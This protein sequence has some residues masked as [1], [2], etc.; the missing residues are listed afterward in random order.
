MIHF[1]CTKQVL[2]GLNYFG[3]IV[4]AFEVLS[5]VD[6][7]HASL[8]SRRFLL[9]VSLGKEISELMSLMN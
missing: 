2:Q 6:V 7:A 4:A 1:G 9:G 8:T 3:E 5:L